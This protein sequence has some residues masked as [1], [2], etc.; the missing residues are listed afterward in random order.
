MISGRYKVNN[1]GEIM[2]VRDRLWLAAFLTILVILMG[3]VGVPAPAQVAAE[4]APKPA[5]LQDSGTDLRIAISGEVVDERGAPVDDC[6]FAVSMRKQFSHSRLPVVRERN[7][8]R[9]WVPVGEVDWFDIA[10]SVRSPDGSRTARES[11]PLFQLRQA[12]TE[13][14]KLTLKPV[15]RFV[16]VTVLDHGKPVPDANVTAEIGGNPF[17]EATTNREGVARFAVTHRDK[18]SQLTAWTDDFRIGGYAFYRNP[19]RNPS[20]SKYTIELERCRPQVVRLL[21]EEDGS[22]AANLRFLLTVGTG[23][24]DFQFPGRTP[25]C[26]MR[27]NEVGEAIYRWF[28]DWKTHGSYI[29]LLDPR[30]V[31]AGEQETAADG[32]MVVRVR[33]SRFDSR[34]RV[35]GQIAVTQGSPAGF[36]VQVRSFQGEEEGRGDDLSAFT[37]EHGTF[38]A[39]YLPGAKYCIQVNDIRYVSDIIDL[40]PCDPTAEAT[41]SPSLTVSEGHPLE[42]TV[43][44]GPAKTPV[45]HQNVLLRTY[46]DFSWQ[47]GDKTEHGSGGR[48]WSV[49]TDAAGRARAFAPI[50]KLTGRIFSFS[51]EWR[52]EV[53]VDVKPDGA[54]KLEFHREQ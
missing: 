22:P 29:E 9:F 45:S 50:G 36:Y 14:L 25:E 13:G 2:P 23:E 38:A 24:P 40:I 15:E 19:P 18:L 12:A 17:A 10:V 8:F 30:W 21:K 47:E 11:L 6:R 49:K 7:R 31:K 20:E 53:T 1:R 28:P 42:I 26:E 41:K 35:V 34:K 32:A 43:T 33:K 3:L 46:H 16:D 51:D 5:W 27:T 48:H 52:P 44:S 4:A 39:D 54:T 37:D